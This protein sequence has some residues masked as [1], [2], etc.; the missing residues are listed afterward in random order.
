MFIIHPKN[1]FVPPQYHPHKEEIIYVISGKAKLNYFKKNSKKDKVF[2]LNKENFYHVIP[3]KQIHNIE[4]I[5]NY[6]IFLE[7]SLGPFN[8]NNTLFPNWLEKYKIIKNYKL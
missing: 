6:F 2:I 4:I 7:I 1:Y 5:S 8:K 3:K